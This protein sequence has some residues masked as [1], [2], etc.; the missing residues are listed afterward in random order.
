MRQIKFRAWDKWHRE[1]FYPAANGWKVVDL[2]AG[3]VKNINDSFNDYPIMQFTG[4]LDKN[5]KEI[6]E[7][8]LIQHLPNGNEPRKIYEIKWSGTDC[9]WQ[10]WSKKPSYWDLDIHMISNYKVIGNIYENPELISTDWTKV[11]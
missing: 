7:G 5:G 4:L 10:G 6:Y 2:E 8:D 1:M 11:K 3:R 9:R